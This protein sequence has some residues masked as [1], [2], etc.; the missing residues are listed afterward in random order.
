MHRDH[1]LLNPTCPGNHLDELAGLI[2]GDM[3]K[4]DTSGSVVRWTVSSIPKHGI[5]DV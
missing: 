2:R 4:T 5:G 3:G 1:L